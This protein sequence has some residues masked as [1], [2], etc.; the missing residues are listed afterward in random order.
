M[1]TAHK[2][3]FYPARG[4]SN[5]GSNILYQ[6]TLMYSSKDLPG[7]LTLK[8]RKL[9]QG[10][11][12]DIK[13]IDFK[14]DLLER[15]NKLKSKGI[16]NLSLIGSIYA[17]S[18]EADTNLLNQDYNQDI[19]SDLLKIEEFNKKQ[20]LDS[21]DIS[22]V[23]FQVKTNN[24]DLSDTENNINDNVFVQDIDDEF[25]D[26]PENE[27]SVDDDEEELMKEFEKIKK[28]R[29]EEKKQKD[30]EE[31]EHIKEKNREN[32]LLGNPLLNTSLSSNY[33]LN[34]KWYE[35]TVFKNQSKNEPKVKKRFINDTVRSDF[36]RKF[37]AKSIQ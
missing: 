23:K 29:E 25:D 34:K 12:H 27:N 18:E 16:S 21:N 11:K 33:S 28:M 22:E 7:N 13:N 31:A 10:N 20:R 24:K 37:I 8:K 32:V 9:G 5:Q 14:S 3:T 36:H 15:E 6:P 19:T 30:I 26:D 17:D 35:D 4:S 1:T 2:P